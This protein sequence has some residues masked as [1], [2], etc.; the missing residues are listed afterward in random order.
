MNFLKIMHSKS[1]V[2]KT[3]QIIDLE[4]SQLHVDIIEGPPKMNYE[5]TI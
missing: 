4:T 2:E 1:A 3:S 5:I